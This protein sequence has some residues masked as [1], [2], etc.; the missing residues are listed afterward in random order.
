MSLRVPWYL[1][2]GGVVLGALLMTGVT[3]WLTPPTD[4]GSC[5]SIA[6]WQHT[7]TPG[8]WI[9]VDDHDDILQYCQLS[10][11][12][13]TAVGQ[14]FC[15]WNGAPHPAAWLRTATPEAREAFFAQRAQSAQ[16]AAEDDAICR[17]L[18]GPVEKEKD[19]CRWRA[20]MQRHEQTTTRAQWLEDEKALVAAEDAQAARHTVDT[21]RRRQV[22]QGDKTLEEIVDLLTSRRTLK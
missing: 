8:Q 5:P 14:Q 6:H 3:S 13:L 2:L 4:P 7:C 1:V 11:P 19:A 17:D 20:G 16:E 21:L 9:A 18:W 15:R 12:L 22:F 10:Q